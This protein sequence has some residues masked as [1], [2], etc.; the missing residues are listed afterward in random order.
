M[1]ARG[2]KPENEFLRM[3]QDVHA[4]SLRSEV[5]WDIQALDA[6]RIKLSLPALESHR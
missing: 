4:V 1:G 3:F 5:A 6:G 2:L